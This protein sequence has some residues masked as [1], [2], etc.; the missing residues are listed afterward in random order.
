MR[1]DEDGTLG[2]PDVMITD[3]VRWH[4]AGDHRRRRTLGEVRETLGTC[5]GPFGKGL[6]TEVVFTPD[7]LEDLLAEIVSL[8]NKRGNR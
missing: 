8:K 1:R 7:D 2:T 4:L 5:Q 3:R 6:E